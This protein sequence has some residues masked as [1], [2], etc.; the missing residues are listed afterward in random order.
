MKIGDCVVVPSGRYGAITEILH[1]RLFKVTISPN[2]YYW[3]SPHHL[4]T[5]PLREWHEIRL[6]AN[7]NHIG[8]I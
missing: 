5:A 4:Q 6:K 7:G 2:G 8:V 3:F 1:S